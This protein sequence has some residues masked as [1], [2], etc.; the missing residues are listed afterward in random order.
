MAAAE[1][2]GG[3]AASS[4][5][6]RIALGTTNRAKLESVE[7][8]ARQMFST[9][10]VWPCAADR[11]VPTVQLPQPSRAPLGDQADPVELASQPF[12]ISQWRE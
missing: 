8:A 12:V 6:V 11:S 9:H 5:H 7:A 3:A 1:H 10:S 2:T 4:T